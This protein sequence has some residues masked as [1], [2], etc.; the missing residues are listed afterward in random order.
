LIT[1]QVPLTSASISAEGRYK[2]RPDFYVAA[3]Y[4]Y[5]GFSDETGL[6]GTFPWDAPVTRVEVG[7]GYS[8]QRNLLLKGSFQ[9][10]RRDGGRLQ[11]RAHL[12]AAQLVFWF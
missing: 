1:L 8:I 6:L 5:L 3:R 4:D 12:A 11:P 10:D 9:Y 2:L 7:G